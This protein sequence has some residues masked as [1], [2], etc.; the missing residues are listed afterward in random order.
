M[1][2]ETLVNNR[3]FQRI[4]LVFTQPRLYPPAHVI[5]HLPSMTVHL[6]TLLQ[7]SCLAAIWMCKSL[8]VL[9]SKQPWGKHTLLTSA[10]KFFP[11]VVLLM[12]PLRYFAMPKMFGVANIKLLDELVTD[13]D[14]QHETHA[15]HE[16]MTIS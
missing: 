6:F 16:L 15:E 8:S 4:T 1:G 13:E 12:L 7:F 11:L 10:G 14:A 5:R 9:T 2:M 3:F